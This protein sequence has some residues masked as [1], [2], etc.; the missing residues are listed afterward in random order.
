MNYSSMYF[1]NIM[2]HCYP[3]M[4]LN[5]KLA[6]AYVPYQYFTCIYPPKEGLSRGT[7]FP[8]LD[9]PYGFDPEY[10]VDA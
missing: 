7:I 8:G 10:T 2:Q 3:V 6:H 5:P 9:R 1:N 4:P